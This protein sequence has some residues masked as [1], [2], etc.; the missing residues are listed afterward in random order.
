[1]TARIV[2]EGIY[3]DPDNEPA[4]GTADHALWLVHWHV[5]LEAAE[6]ITDLAKLYRDDIEWALHFPGVDFEYQGKESVLKHYEELF[7]ATSD[8]E[9]LTHDVYAT[10]NRVF[11]DQT[12]GYT[13][14]PDAGEIMD[15]SVVPPGGRVTGR[16]LHNFTV[17]DGLIAK[18]IAYFVPSA[19]G[20]E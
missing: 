18:E 5:A 14:S 11:I 6:R 7:R 20:P 4:V 9:D 12:I 3:A 16:L 13:I 19:P 2:R 10:P 15:V 17:E 8:F 1:M